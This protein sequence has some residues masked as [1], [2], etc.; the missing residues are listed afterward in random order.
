MVQNSSL[1]CSAYVDQ[2][3][4]DR[5]AGQTLDPEPVPVSEVETDAA[6]ALI[7]GCRFLRE[8]DIG[9]TL[10]G[11]FDV[12]V[13]IAAIADV[14]R[15]HSSGAHPFEKLFLT[16]CRELKPEDLRALAVACPALRQ[17]DLLG[18]REIESSD[19]DFLLGVCPRLQFLDLSFCKKITSLDQYPDWARQGLAIKRSSV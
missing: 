9:W 12:S 3:R 4:Q 5:R 13:L 11:Q 14:G 2:T 19:I 10:G 15:V 18:A 6:V 16:T 17:L 8:L 7:K 1:R